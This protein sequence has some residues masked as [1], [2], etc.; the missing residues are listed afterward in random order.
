MITNR[1]ERANAVHV[2]PPRGP[3]RLLLA[4]YL[5]LRPV[6]LHSVS[7]MLSQAMSRRH[8]RFYWLGLSYSE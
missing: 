7:F 5:W 4:W 3:M 8:I 2:V 6:E 1:D